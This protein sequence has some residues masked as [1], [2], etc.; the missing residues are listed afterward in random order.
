MWEKEG[1]ER[2]EAVEKGYNLDDG[3]HIVTK[4][5]MLY[6]DF[7]SSSPNQIRDITTSNI[8]LGN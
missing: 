7:S 1:A 8:S 4:T 6:L 2:R 3:S 5:L